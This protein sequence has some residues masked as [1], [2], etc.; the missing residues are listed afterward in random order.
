M[1]STH[2]HDFVPARKV[3]LLMG[4]FRFIFSLL[5]KL[6]QVKTRMCVPPFASQLVTAGSKHLALKMIK[7][8]AMGE[9]NIFKSWDL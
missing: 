7:G 9:G 8:I 6:S 4:Q 3:T 1:S 5:G 2:C